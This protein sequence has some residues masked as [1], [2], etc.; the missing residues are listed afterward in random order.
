MFRTLLT[1][2]SRRME[3]FRVLKR[4]R[5]ELG[6]VSSHPKAM[7]VQVNRGTVTL[8]GPVLNTEVVDILTGVESVRGVNALQYELDG[9]DSADGVSSLR[10][11]SAVGSREDSSRHR[12]APAARAA[13]TAGLVATGA[14]AMMRARA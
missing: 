10:L 5:S 14:W 9:Y 6:H 12:W 13:L 11:R 3:D 1:N 4:V 8:R 2:A 7:D